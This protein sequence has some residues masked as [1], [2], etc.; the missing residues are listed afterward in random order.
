M[1]PADVA[2]RQACRHALYNGASK[3]TLPMK[4]L[5]LTVYILDAVLVFFLIPFAMF[6]YQGDLETTVGK[7][8][9]S[10]LM[11][12]LSSAIICALVLGILYGYCLLKFNVLVSIVAQAVCSAFIA[13][14]SSD[15]TWTKQATFPEYVVALATIVGSVLF[16][17]DKD[18]YRLFFH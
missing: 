17:V 5:W 18:I 9:K 10:A 6:Y 8:I 16:S 15:K 13:D 11:W 1:L 14:A 12:V 4:D 7:R 3:L 2:N